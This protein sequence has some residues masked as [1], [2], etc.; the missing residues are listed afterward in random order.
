MRQIII[1]ASVGAVLGLVIAG[2]VLTESVPTWAS[3]VLAPGIAADWQGRLA[4]QANA[5]ELQEFLS[6][7]YFD[8][9]APNVLEFQPSILTPEERAMVDAWTN[10]VFRRAA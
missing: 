8:P 3:A 7:F 5:A 4:V 2:L 9:A 10:E 1:A 6:T